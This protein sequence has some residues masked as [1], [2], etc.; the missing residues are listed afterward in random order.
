MFLCV[1]V[2]CCEDIDYQHLEKVHIDI[3]LV[4]NGM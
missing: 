4:L 3:F 2:Y 1:G